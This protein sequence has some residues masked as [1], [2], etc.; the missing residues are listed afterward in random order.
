M[1][2]NGTDF[3]VTGMTE[4]LAVLAEAQGLSLKRTTESSLKSSGKNLVTA[5]R[6][7]APTGPAPHTS[8]QKGKRGR[9]GPL[10]QKVTTKVLRPRHGEIAAIN[11]GPRAWYKHFVIRGTKPHIISATSRSGEQAPGSDVRSMNRGTLKVGDRFVFRVHH[12]GA[13]AND[14]VHRAARGQGDRITADLKANVELKLR[15]AAGL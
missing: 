1:S 14:F 3:R 5:I 13:R 11:T 15:A 7:E 4:L 10:A 9:K 2:S 12:P 8:A 6:R